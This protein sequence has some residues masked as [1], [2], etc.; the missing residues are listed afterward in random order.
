MLRNFIR[1]R[2]GIPEENVVVTSYNNIFVS[3]TTLITGGAEKGEFQGNLYWLLG[4]KPFEV[5]GYK[6]LEAWSKATGQERIGGALAGKWADPRLV[7]PGF[8]TC[9]EPKQLARIKEYMVDRNSPCIGAGVP[10]K[11][12]GGRDFWGHKLPDKAKPSVGACER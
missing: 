12:N 4:G 6:S 1:R 3:G 10:I 5:D 11:N 7:R 2:S 8:A 9:A